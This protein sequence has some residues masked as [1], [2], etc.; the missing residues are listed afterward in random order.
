MVMMFIIIGVIFFF[1][2]GSFLMKKVDDFL[3]EN[4]KYMMKKNRL[5]E[6]DFIVLSSE[7]SD[8]EMVNEIHKYRKNHKNA[9]LILKE[10][11]S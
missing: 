2:L 8:T 10:Y 1:L 5:P 9:Q 7:L 11:H 6:P 3:E 4:K